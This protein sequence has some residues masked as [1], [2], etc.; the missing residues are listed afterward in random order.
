MSE[1]ELRTLDS[2]CML[3]GFPL[4]SQKCKVLSAALYVAKTTLPKGSSRRV[5]IQDFAAALNRRKVLSNDL[6]DEFQQLGY[7]YMEI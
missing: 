3:L 1:A 7:R 2:I 5:F 6:V 4:S